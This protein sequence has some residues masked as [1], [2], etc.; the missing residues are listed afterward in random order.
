MQLHS[1]SPILSV[2][3]CT[4]NRADKL[5]RA[6]DSVLANSFTDF[7]LI[8]VDQSTDGRTAAAL[9]TIDDEPTALH[10][11]RHGRRG[12]VAQQGGVAKAAP[13]SSSTPTMIAS[14]MANGWP[15]S[16]PSSRANP[17]VLAVYGRVVPYGRPRGH[18]LSRASTN[19]PKGWCSKGRPFR[20][21]R[22]GGGNNMAF[23]KE[24][25]QQG[26]TVPGVARAPARGSTTPRIPSSA[27]ACCSTAA[28]LCTPQSPWFSTTSGSTGP[29]SPI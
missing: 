7:E 23:R 25:V 20:P 13:R 27:S 10:P 4:R 2:L 8:V 18:D 5:K 14:A 24:R 26:R 21:L 9:A 17:S 11:Y 28:R 19:R 12:Q 3:I 6:V 16:T 22:L 1:E 29:G 15:R